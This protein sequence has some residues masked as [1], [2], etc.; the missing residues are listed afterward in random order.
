M[1]NTLWRNI[2]KQ[3]T[4]CERDNKVPENKSDV[5]SYEEFPG[6]IKTLKRKSARGPDE[7]PNE[8]IISMSMSQKVTFADD[9]A[10]TMERGIKIKMSKN[11]ENKKKRN[12]LSASDD[13]QET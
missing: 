7:I 3:K 12:T 8:L 9:I 10:K 6:V 1:G 2:Q 13:T 11:K 4:R 5:P